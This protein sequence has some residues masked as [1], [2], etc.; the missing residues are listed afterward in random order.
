MPPAVLARIFEPFFSTKGSGGTGIGL[1]IVY[2]VVARHGGEVRVASAIG[3]GTTFT[4]ALPLGEAAPGGS[5]LGMPE[6]GQLPA[7][8][9]AAAVLDGLA[10]LL[11]D[12][13]PAFRSVFARRLALDARRVEVAADAASALALL[14]TS[15]WDVLLVDDR[16]PDMTGRQLA[17]AIRDRGLDCAIVL[18]SGFATGPNDPALLAP[19]VDG[20]LPKPCTDAEL[21]RVL[22][23]VRQ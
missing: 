11:V 15:A 4:V 10:V 14:E 8:E 5:A 18:V 12:D 2:G 19:G 20:V 13:D 23:Q 6:S 7:D 9:D 16:L 1:A 21:G 3:A 22:R 17:A